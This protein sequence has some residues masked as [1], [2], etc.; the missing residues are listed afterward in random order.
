MKNKLQASHSFQKLFQSVFVVVVIIALVGCMNTTSTATETAEIGATPKSDPTATV[1]SAPELTPTPEMPAYLQVDPDDLAGIVVRFVH[2]WMGD[3][4]A[5]IESIATEFSLTNP[6]DIWVEVEAYGGEN[7]LLD[8]IQLDL[9]TNNLPG[10][11]AVHPYQLSAL[12]GDFY[13]VTLTNY[14]N[15]P[16]WG[17]DADAQVDILP[18][19]LE[20]FIV[21]GNLI[22]LPVAPQATVL[23]YNQ[24]W[25][26]E[27]GYASPPANERDFRDQSCAATFANWQTDDDSQYGTG[28]WVVSLDPVVLVSWYDAFGGEFTV[29]EIPVFNNSAGI[30][31]FSYLKSLN[32]EGCIWGLSGVREPNQSVYFANRLTL[33]YAG[34]L[35][36][37][38]AQRGWLDAVE[39]EDQWAVIGFPGAEDETLLINDTGLTITADNPENQLAAWLFAKHLLEPEVQAQVVQGLFTLP[40]RDSAMESLVDFRADYPQWAQAAAMIESAGVVPVS[41]VWGLVQR[42]LQD[43]VSRIMF[44]DE[45]EISVILSELDSMI[46]DIE[47]SA[48]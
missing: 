5:V 20:Q 37:I 33:M 15:H 13:P 46:G 26:N 1:T 14:F 38:P 43:A 6:W 28:G 17:F 32:E 21:E 22:A 25:A 10:L 42:L 45:S 9:E 12:E 18:I 35:D 41:N 3:G 16:D 34:T 4:A 11:I 39:N 44:M 48:P 30:A 40:V 8:A 29:N 27:L 19:F 7:V 36:Q 23:F 24:T 47:G 31:A 2:P